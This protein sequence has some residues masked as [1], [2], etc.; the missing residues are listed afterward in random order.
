MDAK[1]QLVHEI[2]NLFS[3]IQLTV[4]ESQI[5]SENK[6]KILHWIKIASLFVYFE[7]IFLGEKISFSKRDE[8]IGKILEVVIVMNTTEADKK[9]VKISWGKSGISAFTDSFLIENAMD[10]LFKYLISESKDI[11]VN[12]DQENKTVTIKTGAAADIKKN[13]ISKSIQREN[14]HNMNIPLQLALEIFSILGVKTE[15]D[16]NQIIL[17]F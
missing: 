1:D 17:R 14:L 3:Y 11:S 9:N 16:E 5:T 13:P 2:S 8:D 6:E 4:S 12:T 15:S 7:K 10:M